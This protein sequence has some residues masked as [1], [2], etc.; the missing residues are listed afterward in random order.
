MS[1]DEHEM[2]MV[3]SGSWVETWRP[4]ETA[5]DLIE[6]GDRRKEMF[7]EAEC[8]CGESFL[9][10]DDAYEHLKEVKRGV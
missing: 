5:P 3:Q 9:D 6:S 10:E 7:I 4:G 2:E 8:S 1:S